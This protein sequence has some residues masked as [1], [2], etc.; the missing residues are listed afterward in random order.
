VS[1][2]ILADAFGVSRVTITRWRSD[3]YSEDARE[4]WEQVVAAL[5]ETGAARYEERA[6]ELRALAAELRATTHTEGRPN[7]HAGE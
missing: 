7:D 4:G 6:A 1:N 2:A 5:A 3:E